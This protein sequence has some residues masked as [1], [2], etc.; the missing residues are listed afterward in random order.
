MKKLVLTIAIGD[1]YQQIAKLTH[2]TLKAYAKRIGA[3]F[4]SINE[5]RISKTSPHWEKFQ[6]YDWLKEYDRIIYID[7]DIIVRDDTPDLFEE[8]D[9]MKLGMFNEGRFT[10]RGYD[11]IYEMCKAYN[12]TLENW[13]GKEKS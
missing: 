12:V 10:Q 3:D 2:P 5:T 9:Y 13:N 1:E 7:T 6:I 11:L 4:H 8:V